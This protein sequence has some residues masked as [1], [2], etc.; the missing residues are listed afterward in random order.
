MANVTQNRPLSPHLQIYKPIPTMIMSIVHRITGGAL[1]FGTVLVA[2]WL[3]AA[4]TGQGYFELVNWIM[5]TIIG[6]LVLFGYTWALL[7]H[8]LG[9]LRHFMW[10][11]GYGFGKEFSTKLAKATLVGSLC[12]TAL[13]WIIGI[14][15]RLV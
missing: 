10:D 4:A 14:A 8:M 2:W 7:H 9:G 6:R 3:I 5:G 13:V 12:L 1:Y 11:L 15:I